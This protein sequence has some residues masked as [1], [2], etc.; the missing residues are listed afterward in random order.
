MGAAAVNRDRLYSLFKVMVNHYSPS[1]REEELTNHIARYLKGSSLAVTREYV[2]D[3][4]ANLLI[5]APGAKA[6][7]LFLGHIDTVPAFDIEQYEF[8]EKEGM[9]F[10][11]GT[12]DMKGGCAAMIEAFLCASENEFLP[13]GVMLAL[14]VGEE[15]TGDGTAARH[16]VGRS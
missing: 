12:A 15:E 3:T 9:C 1:G 5:A 4:R 13:A 14:V 8:H 16:Q 11:L 2:D 10:G 7:T 6:E